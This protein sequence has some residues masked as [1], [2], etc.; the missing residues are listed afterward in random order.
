MSHLRCPQ[1]GCRIDVFGTS[2][3]RKTVEQCGVS[4]LGHLPLD[5]ELAVT[6]DEGRIEDYESES[7][8]VIARRVL[9]AAAPRPA[10][11]EQE[12]VISA[13]PGEPWRRGQIGTRWAPADTASARTAE[14]GCPIAGVR[15]ARTSAARSAAPRCCERVPGT[16]STGAPSSAGRRGGVRRGTGR[17]G[18]GSAGP[19]GWSG[20]PREPRVGDEATGRSFRGRA[21]SRLPWVQGET[22]VG[23]PA[24]HEA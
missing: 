6:C 8:Q 24:R 12:P 19:Q 10:S 21:P 18:R 11:D 2:R 17:A 7:F 13:Q 14:G 15:T 1:C 23:T 9:E 20:L 4:M 3:A 16:T 5:P 22:P